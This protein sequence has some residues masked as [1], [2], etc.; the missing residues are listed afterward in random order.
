MAAAA[1]DDHV[2]PD[3]RPDP[4]DDRRVRALRQFAAMLRRDARDLWV[5][6][7]DPVKNRAFIVIGLVTMLVL[8]NIELLW[9]LLVLMALIGALIVMIRRRKRK[10]ERERDR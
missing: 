5:W 8:M 4:E 9:P 10:R 1:S 7:P 6:L 3:A 2:P